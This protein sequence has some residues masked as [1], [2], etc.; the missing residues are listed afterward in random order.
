L[1]AIPESAILDLPT[2]F[3]Y[4][5]RRNTTGHERGGDSRACHAD[6]PVAPRECAARKR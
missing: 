3:R 1:R 2:G 6:R 5:P 4:R